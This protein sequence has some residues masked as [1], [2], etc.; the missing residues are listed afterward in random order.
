MRFT[1]APLRGAF[2]IELEALVDSRGFFAR[3]FCS[4]EFESHGLRPAIAQYNLS[5]NERRGTLRGLHYQLPPAAEAKFMRCIAGAIYDVIVD[6]RPD[7][8]TYLQ[9]FGVELSAG[10]RSALYVPEQF[11]HGYQALTDGAEVLYTVSQHYAPG[12]ERGIRYDDPRLAISWP[13]PV[14]DL[15]EKDAAWPP[16]RGRPAVTL[17]R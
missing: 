15:S 9:H 17:T 14:S 4:R 1:E 7:S 2:L 3:G 10:N 12:L 6:L 16:L 5:Y 13:L 11:G 8:P